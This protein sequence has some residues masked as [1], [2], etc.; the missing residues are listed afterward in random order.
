NAM[1]SP[2]NR[3]ETGNVC[4]TNPPRMSD[5]AATNAHPPADNMPGESR[6]PGGRA[7]R[8]GLAVRCGCEHGCGGG[9]SDVAPR[10]RQT[11]GDPGS[12]ARCGRELDRA[13]VRVGDRLGDRE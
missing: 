13:A 8:Y 1:A 7:R 9:R 2:T 5:A 10:A 12:G 3:G 4:A 11:H 6:A